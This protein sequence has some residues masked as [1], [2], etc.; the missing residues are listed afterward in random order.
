MNTFWRRVRVAGLVS[1]VL[2][3][4]GASRGAEG[5]GN[6]RVLAESVRERRVIAF[7]YNGHARTVEPHALG[8]ATDDQ[9]ALLAWQTSG[10][11]STESPPG[12][13]VFLVAEIVDLKAT[14]EVFA[15]PRPDYRPGRSRG[16]KSVEAEIA[17]N[18]VDAVR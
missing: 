15:G 16:L 8:R 11:S 12:W 1:L 5:V 17:A 2:A 13:R 6:A 9:P 4:A 7:S 10:G 3:G 14:A 18:P